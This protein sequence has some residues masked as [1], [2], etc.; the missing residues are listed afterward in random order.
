MR[1]LTLVHCDPEA[2][3]LGIPFHLSGKRN[4]DG[5]R[6]RTQ[7]PAQFQIMVLDVGGKDECIRSCAT[8]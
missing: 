6:I 8:L 1:N 3:C 2:N 7:K 4:Q 5:F